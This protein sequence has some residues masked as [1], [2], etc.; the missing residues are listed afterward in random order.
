V[1]RVGG[2]SSRRKDELATPLRPVPKVVWHDLECGLET[3]DL[4]LWEELADSAT[5]A[6][7]P[8]LELG[9]GTGRVGLHLARGGHELVGVDREP[10]LVAAFNERAALEELP[11]QAIV[12]DVREVHLRRGFRLA[13]AP[14][15]LMQQ[16]G[17]ARERLEALRAIASHLD[18][19]ARAA[20]AIVEEDTLPE[21]ERGGGEVE[22]LPDVRELHGWIFQTRPVR[23]RSGGRGIVIERLRESVSPQGERFT[24]P[25]SD[26]L[27]TLSA[28]RLEEEAKLNRLHP[29]HRYR[30]DAHGVHAPSTVVVVERR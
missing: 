24:E 25:H 6:S 22:A 21:D 17:D 4:P 11:A 26:L 10:A 30:V 16:I 9:C 19:G 14:M 18:R 29:V 28:D 12:V 7:G 5:S 13:I 3:A 27:D 20:F 15:Q 23:V 2:R 1:T 8:I